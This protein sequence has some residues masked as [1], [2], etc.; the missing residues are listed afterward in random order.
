MRSFNANITFSILFVLT[1][2]AFTSAQAQAFTV[3]HSFL[4]GQDGALPY[5]TLVIDPAGNLYGTT[6][7]GGYFE[8]SFC[9]FGCGI[10]FKLEHVASG[11]I[12]APLYRFQGGAD[13]VSPMA[14]VTFGPDGALYGTTYY[15][16]G[17]PCSNGNY[18]G[19]GTVFRISPPL[20]VCKNVNSVLCSWSETV[21]HRFTG[22]PDG[23]APEANVTFG[24]AGNIFGTTRFGGNT[25][26][27]QVPYGCGT[28]FKM[29]HSSGGWIESVLYSFGQGKEDGILP[30][31]SLT[32]DT[33]GNLYGTTGSGGGS[34][35]YGTVF[36]L[37][38][39]S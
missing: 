15:G 31:A 6:A 1:I 23:E 17:G 36:Q 13:G 3:L 18:T 12:L 29:T 19:C 25:N 27:T 7:Q 21:M 34:N 4:G 10:V 38:R 14:G 30:Q 35:N 8:G 39:I 24:E 37:E 2:L 11:W 26:C 20:T 33:S 5:G 22:T 16:G 9:P 28:V 32:F